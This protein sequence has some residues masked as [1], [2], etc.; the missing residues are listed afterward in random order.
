[1]RKRKRFFS[2]LLALAMIL[3]FMPA[4]AFADAVANDSY[5][6]DASTYANFFA[7]GH[8]NRHS[9]GEAFVA[10]NMYYVKMVNGIGS[11]AD[12]TKI[13]LNNTEYNLSDSFN[14]FGLSEEVVEYEKTI[15]VLRGEKD[16]SNMEKESVLYFM[17]H[18][19]Y[20]LTKQG[21]EAMGKIVTKGVF[22]GCVRVSCR[23]YPLLPIG[24]SI[25]PGITNAKLFCNCCKDVYES[26]GDLAK[27]DGCAFGPTFPNL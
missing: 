16:S 10:D 1:M 24:S 18:Q 21:L 2:I 25:Q 12:G 23:G 26:F 17:I 27:I 9:N 14:L 13:V 6:S 3:T 19:R 20:I 4:M 5:Y 15:R 7:D 22:G 11:L 8:Y